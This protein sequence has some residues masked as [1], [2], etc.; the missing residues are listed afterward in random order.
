MAQAE[1]LERRIP[2]VDVDPLALLGANDSYLQLIE[3]RLGGSVIVRGNTVILRGEP[4]E[5]QA[6][7]ALFQEL[8]YLLRRNGRLLPEDVAMAVDLVAVENVPAARDPAVAD[9]VIFIGRQ[10]PI[11]ARTPRQLEYWHKVQT[12]DIVFAIGPAG[13]GKT[14]LAVAMALAA[15]RRN[16]VSR[17][18]LSRP[19][20]EAGE[21]LGFL[22]GD[23]QEK[24]DPYLRPLTDALLEM[25]GVDKFRSMTD[26][27]II[28]V[29]P[30]AY[31][32]G[33]TLNDAF[34]ILDEAQNTTIGQMKMF[35]TRLGRNAKAI[36]TGDI[37]Q[38]DLEDP[39]V[40]GLV[41]VQSV[42]QGVPGIA[43]VYFD[44]RDVV[45]HR[46]VADIIEAYERRQQRNSETGQ[47]PG[48]SYH[49]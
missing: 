19:A 20:V 6:L 4:S 3:R 33:R 8:L 45:R 26:R 48:D 1:L 23:L 7:E 16:E 12:H 11:R 15:L 35:L 34:L 47:P 28:E 36:V 13:T 10:G 41:D 21:S 38:I 49:G 18:I 5:V 14:Y 22:P 40:S 39:S 24:V 25:L 31:M 42:L 43:F 44:R 27:R 9:D 46:L 30:L 32:R 37:T 29:I 17:L 2:L